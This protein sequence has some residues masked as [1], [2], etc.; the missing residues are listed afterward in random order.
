[1]GQDIAEYG[2]VFKI[3]EG[4]VEKFGKERVRNTPIC[5]SAIVGAGLGLSVKGMKSMVEMQFAD[6]VTE[7]FNQIVNNLGKIPLAMGSKCPMWL[8]G[9][10]QAQ[11]PLLG[12]FILKAM[13]HGSFIHRD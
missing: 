9:C 4:F 3:T 1:M 2:G 5:E 7:G 8:S 13:K 11:E 6:F 12:R 10:Q